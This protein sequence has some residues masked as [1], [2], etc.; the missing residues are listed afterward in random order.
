MAPLWFTIDEL[1][2]PVGKFGSCFV[3]R[4]PAKTSTVL[5]P[6]PP[7]TS[8]TENLSVNENNDTLGLG[9]D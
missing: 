7:V 1:K 3:P 6:K 2:V 4:S 5:T 9:I 8:T